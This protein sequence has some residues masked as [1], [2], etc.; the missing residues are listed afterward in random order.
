MDI[1]FQGKHNSEEAIESLCR[2][3]E[4][5]KERYQICQFREMRLTM[6]LVDEQGD[7]VELVDSETMDVYR[8]FEVHR[9]QYELTRRPSTPILK[10]VID[11]TR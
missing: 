1:I 3:I 8:T 6:T 4:L 5:F 10:L 2:V 11:N 7:D 9:E